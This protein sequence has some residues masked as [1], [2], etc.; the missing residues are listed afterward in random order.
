M[1][2]RGNAETLVIIS[3]LLCSALLLAC[4][5]AG[6]DRKQLQGA[7]G[8]TPAATPMGMR[9]CTECHWEMANQWLQTRHGNL[10]K[11]NPSNLSYGGDPTILGIA[12]CATACHNP[13]LNDD[14]VATLYD[15]D[16]LI[17]NVTGNA[18]RPVVGCE[19]C[20]GNGSNH[21][22]AGPIG[23]YRESASQLAA[24]FVGTTTTINVTAT[25]TTVPQP[26][27]INVTATNTT[28]AIQ[29]NVTA[30]NTFTRPAG[31]FITDGFTAG[32]NISTSGFANG[33]N[34]GVF[35][36]ASVT[37]TTIK[38]T[39]STL[40]TETGTGDELIS[41]SYTFTRPAGSFVADAFAAGMTIT[42]SGF[43]NTKNNGTFTI[44]EVT[45]TTIKITASVLV[46]ETNT[47]GQLITAS[48]RFTRT[49]AGNFVTDGF[50]PG[51]VITT[52]GFAKT[53]NNGSFVIANV[54]PLEIFLTTTSLVVEAGTGNESI[55]SSAIMA[56]SQFN[57]C[58]GCHELLD[59][60][61]LIPTKAVAIA[62]HRTGGPV[63]PAS[64]D[65][66]ITDTHF[67]T[68][69]D[70][71]AGANINDI[72]GYAIDYSSN[73][74]CSECHYPHGPI[75]V[76]REWANSAHADKTALGA[77]AHYK[78]SDANRT[79]CQRCHTTT[80]YAAYANALETGNTA[81]ADGISAGTTPAMAAVAEFKP[82]MLKCMGCHK[83]NKGA[84]RNPGAITANYDYVSSGTTYAKASH[85]FPDLSNSNICMAC[86]TGREN[87]ETIANL[88]T[89]VKFENQSFINSHYLTGGATMF[90]TSG[91][92]YPGRSY[93]NLNT[94]LHDK[95]G[96]AAI[97]RTG[98]RGPCIGCHMSRPAGNGDHLFMPVIRETTLLA[99]PND[100]VISGIASEVCIVCH[101]T[102]NTVIK[103][104]VNEQRVQYLE[105][106]EALDAELAV[107]GFHFYE[108]NPYFF[109]SAAYNPAYT[110]TGLCNQNLPIKNWQTG[111]TSEFHWNGS[112]CVSFAVA[113]GDTGTGKHNMGAAF[114]FNML[115]HDKG[116]YVHNRQY[117]KRLIYDA[118]DW[119]D[120]NALD[121]SVGATLMSRCGG[122]PA[123]G[124]CV[125]A[126]P[127][128]LPN[129]VSG[130][131]AERP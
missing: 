49:D 3:A 88:S 41:A 131:N 59:T 130:Y 60:T 89:A 99:P 102:S 22:G 45:A 8:T 25:T 29:I 106:L 61:A 105:A 114:N 63:L 119:L 26:T 46:T 111:G 64:N 87:G 48:N 97:P 71:S 104:I 81:L 76:H 70:F 91:Y 69:G 113:A 39:T 116:A 128:L 54:T 123:T 28:G 12:G 125:G 73:T 74:A 93:E 96:S 121:Y 50:I 107:R 115:H 30:T 65:D 120:N 56:S 129:G 95:I 98:T 94:F 6:D 126:I 13:D 44:A 72:T 57:T 122:P 112:S 20:H 23:P 85:T 9:S 84:L 40:V 21:N 2:R 92:E 11:N 33:A 17:T 31:S 15:S 55:T 109:V 110:E 51:R 78:W 35:K 19:A 118:I 38:I 68:A 7:S 108:A 103:D 53:Q 127:Y 37:A 52:S 66:N 67:A 90:A 5:A 24:G 83:D 117:V 32:V 43:T 42:T 27:T 10:D 14:V 62:T 101:I 36:V 16:Y 77:W 34:N 79:A 124:Y 75:T 100:V 80:A 1:K 18:A 4:G 58:T 86:H 47:G 82:E